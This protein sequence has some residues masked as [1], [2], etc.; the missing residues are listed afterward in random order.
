VQASTFN[1]MYLR[2]DWW[3]IDKS[4]RVIHHICYQI[5]STISGLRYVK[6]GPSQIQYNYFSWYSGSNIQLIVSPLRLVVYRQIDACYTSHL[7]P[8]TG[9]NIRITLCQL[10]SRSNPIQLHFLI[11]SLQCPIERTLFDIGEMSTI[12]CAL[13]S[14]FAAE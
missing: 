4:M 9:H 6:S 8:N 12:Q 14:T 1:W 13:S 5:Q 7:L 11:F 2:C 3:I 10:W